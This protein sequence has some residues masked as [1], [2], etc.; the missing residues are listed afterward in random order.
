ME[1]VPGSPISRRASTA[2]YWRAAKPLTLKAA[3]NA[4]A[5]KAVARCQFHQRS[6]SSFSKLR[7]QMREKDC[8]V[9]S[10]FLHFWDLG[11]YKLL[12]KHL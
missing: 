2:S 1:P 9:I 12:I 6:T 7:S 11:L 5:A 3:Q 8:Q 10:F 4:S